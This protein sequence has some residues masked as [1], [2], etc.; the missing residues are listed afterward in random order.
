MIKLPPHQSQQCSLN[1]SVNRSSNC[2]QLEAALEA[3]SAQRLP[4]GLAV[5][6]LSEDGFSRPLFFPQVGLRV[7]QGCLR[8]S[9]RCMRTVFMG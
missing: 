5:V 9:L 1:R 7:L 6:Q 8:R 3:Y 4:D 2:S